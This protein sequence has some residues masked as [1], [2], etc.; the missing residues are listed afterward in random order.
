MRISGD[1]RG[2]ITDIGAARPLLLVLDYPGRCTEA[3]VADLGLADDGFE[4][5]DLMSARLPRV[6]DPVGYLSTLLDRSDVTD[7]G[8]AVAVLGYCAGAPLACKLA[9]SAE[10]RSITGYL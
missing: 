8:R 6:C 10:C 2:V 4:V 9:G 3:R 1:R 7:P 5:A